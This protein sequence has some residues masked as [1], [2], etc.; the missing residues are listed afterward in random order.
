MPSSTQSDKRRTLTTSKIIEA[1][2]S[3]A[4]TQGI[5]ALSMRKLAAALNVTA[6]S[7]YNHVANKEDL[8]SLMLDNVVSDFELPDEDGPWKEML[9]RRAHSMRQTFLRHPWAP[10]LLISTITNGAHTMRDANA[11]LGC[12]INAGFSYAAA[13]WARN[14]IDSHTFGYTMQELNFPVEPTEY[15]AAA[16]HYLP[17]ISKNDYPYLHGATKALINGDY[18]G[19]TQFDFG[20]GLILSGLAPDQA[21]DQR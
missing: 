9:R 1:A 10:T 2:L 7:I 16:D 14:A 13:D 4:N 12:L 11:T 3:I 18:D 6:M 8:L 21:P 17:E 19:V 15:R 20:L 5:E